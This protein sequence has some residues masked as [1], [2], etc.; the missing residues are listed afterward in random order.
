MTDAGGQVLDGD[1]DGKEGGDFDFWFEAGS[2]IFVD[3]TAPTGGNGTLASPFQT[4]SAA[5]EAATRRIVVPTAGQAAFRNGD[6]FTVDDGNTTRRSFYLTTDNTAPAT[7]SL[8]R[9]RILLTPGASAASVASTI[10]SAINLQAGTLRVIA[11]SSGAA[12]SI[13]PTITGINPRF[14]VSQTQALLSAPNIVRILGN[15]GTDNNITTTAD[16]IPI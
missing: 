12:V 2:T 1:S 3:K 15:G 11:T 10:A 5:L 7:D 9:V 6:S 4:I 8:G 16:A 13:I 14:D